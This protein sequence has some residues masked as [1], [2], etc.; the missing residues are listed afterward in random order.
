MPCTFS[1]YPDLNLLVVVNAGQVTLAEALAVTDS[2]ENHPDWNGAINELDDYSRVTGIEFSEERARQLATLTR[3]VLER[4]YPRKRNALVAPDARTGELAGFLL[5]E[6]KASRVL[7]GDVF[8]TVPDALRYLG[9][10]SDLDVARV[11]ADID[12]M[13]FQS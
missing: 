4:N 3:G 8:A 12:A 9:V 11:A 5:D 10:E 1:I 7:Q 13:A 6:I 2:I